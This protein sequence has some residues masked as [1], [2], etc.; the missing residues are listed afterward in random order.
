MKSRKKLFLWI[1]IGVFMTLTITGVCIAVNIRNNLRQ[2]SVDQK[3]LYT[4]YAKD[5]T[6][7]A[8]TIINDASVQTSCAG[9][10]CGDK[11]VLKLY[12]KND[13]VEDLALG[14]KIGITYLVKHAPNSSGYTVILYLGDSA[15]DTNQTMVKQETIKNIATS[16]EITNYTTSLNNITISAAEATALVERFGES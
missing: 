11:L 13:Q 4:Q 6:D 7:Q 2:Q 8:P 14:T 3:A 5:I 12:M 15:D 1:G 16:L 10:P 9:I